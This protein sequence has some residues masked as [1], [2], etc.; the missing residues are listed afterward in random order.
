MRIKYV[1]VR[2][3]FSPLFLYKILLQL[4]QKLRGEGATA[5]GLGEGPTINIHNWLSR[6]TLDVIGE[7]TLGFCSCIAISDTHIAAGFGYRI[8]ALDSA[9]K[10][11]LSGVYDNL[12]FVTLLHS[13][14]LMLI[15]LVTVSTLLFTRTLGI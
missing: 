12:L 6:T 1:H 9:N 10:N 14:S 11:E 15:S 8:G 4:V 5:L 13:S 7:C 2:Y 3:L